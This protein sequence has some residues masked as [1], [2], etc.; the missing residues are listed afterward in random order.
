MAINPNLLAGEAEVTV[1]GQTYMI[2][3]EFKY[4]PASVARETL[5]GQDQVHG[6]KEMP[7][8]PFISASIRDAGS[9]TVADFNAM[10]DVT[11]SAML[12]NGKQVIGRGMWTVES[13]DVDTQDAKFEVRWEGVDGCITEVTA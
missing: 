7:R 6:Y 2:A 8:A 4:S 13:Q 3:G 11:I 12:S 1:D 9:L 10:T 5:T